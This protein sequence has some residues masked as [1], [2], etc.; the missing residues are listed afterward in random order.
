MWRLWFADRF[1][2]KV[3]RYCFMDE[4]TF[5][6][7]REKRG[8]KVVRRGMEWENISGSRYWKVYSA[9]D[10]WETA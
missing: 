8:M 6:F 9:P 10:R 5:R 3:A 4:Y 7:L 1:G 2:V